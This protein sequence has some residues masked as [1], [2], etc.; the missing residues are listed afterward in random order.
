MQWKI[1]HKTILRSKQSKQDYTQKIKHL[2]F[3]HYGLNFI[4]ARYSSVSI[5]PV[6]LDGLI[7]RIAKGIDITFGD[8]SNKNPDV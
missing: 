1:S 7:Q 4:R 5:Y 3:T 2:S 6:W 8:L